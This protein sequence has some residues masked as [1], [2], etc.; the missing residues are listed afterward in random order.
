MAWQPETQ[1]L[2]FALVIATLLAYAP[3][4]FARHALD[5][6]IVIE[7]NIAV[8]RGCSGLGEIF[9]KD[10]F[11][12]FMESVGATPQLAGGRYRPLAIATFALE[13]CLFGQ[14]YGDAFREQTDPIAR[15]ELLETKMRDATLAL[16]P[17]RHAVSVL[18]YV[19][20]L[21]VLFAWLRRAR[22]FPSDTIAFATSLLFALHPV[23]AEAV[24]NIK[25]RDE[26]L[27]LLFI[28]SCF[29]FA[30]RA[31][32]TKQ[33]RYRWFAVLFAFLAMLSKEY[34][35]VLFALVPLVLMVSQQ[36]ALLPLIK[37]WTPPLLGV[38]LV[39][40]ALRLHATDPVRGAVLAGQDILN[41][42]FLALRTGAASGSV[43]ATKISILPTYLALLVWPHPLS[44]DYSYATFPYVSFADARVALSVLIHAALLGGGSWLLWRRQVAGLAVAFYAVFL[45]PVSN[46]PFEIGA[47]LGE[48]LVFHA[49]LG[50]VIAAGLVLSRVRQPRFAIVFVAGVSLVHG[51]LT[52]ART[53]QWYDNTSLFLADVKTVPNSALANA[54]AGGFILQDALMLVRQRRLSATPLSASERE[55]VRTITERAKPFLERALAIHPR[56]ANAFVNLGLL[57]WVRDEFADAAAAFSRAA[58]ILP[59]HP[60]LMRYGTNFNVMGNQDARSGNVERAIVSFER[61]TAV[62]PREPRF[63]RDLGGA[64]F[65]TMRFAE[66]ASAF[67]HLLQL[68]PADEDAKRGRD[69]A[70]GLLELENAALAPSADARSVIRFAEA[71]E[72]NAAPAFKERARQVRASLH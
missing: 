63:W 61:A 7:Q 48:R 11:A 2:Q 68:R 10:S 42:P 17:L 41:D 46:L 9:G 37:R 24:A 36:S 27:S 16:A 33:P 20:L 51:G 54:N 59:S 34:A 26:I 22:F 8:H 21:L 38:T 25:S 65:M 70:L 32:Q 67:D 35:V 30:T 50:F 28:L 6:A 56:F 45:L 40:A 69:A 53:R 15:S 31:E 4:F 23:H 57:H 13:Q 14:T 5:D 18:L 58:L 39:Y 60:M 43:L 66:A 29:L 72:T 44:A 64:C 3:A 71:L 47:T 49:S 62:A 1:H 19:C 55:D 52:F 12:G